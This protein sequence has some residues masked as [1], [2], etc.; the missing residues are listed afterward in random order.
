[1]PQLSADSI[2]YPMIR[3]E[4]IDA[5]LHWLPITKVQFETFMCSAPSS[6]F[7]YEWYKRLLG[8]NDRISPQATRHNNYWK[9]FMTGL[10]PS[11]VQKFASFCGEEYDLPS[12]EE[13]NSVFDELREQPPIS[14]EDFES[15]DL[16]PRA[17]ITVKKLEAARSRIRA[18]K[19]YGLASQMFLDQG[20]VEWVWHEEDP[21]RWG[22]R[23]QTNKVFHSRTHPIESRDPVPARAPEDQRI[24]DFGARLVRR[25][26]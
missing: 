17:R 18:R 8:A 23:G 9:L 25:T 6:R 5:T 7:G 1:M 26:S 11:E 14:I 4:S 19:D 13:W 16:N 3:V 2:G 24:R 22:G 21:D 15:V 20:V 12:L 10:Y